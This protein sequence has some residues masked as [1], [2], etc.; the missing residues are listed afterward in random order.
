MATYLYLASASSFRS[1]ETASWDHSHYQCR[2]SA[3]RITLLPLPIARSLGKSFSF[4]S[5]AVPFH[6]SPPVLTFNAVSKTGFHCGSCAYWLRG[7]T[8]SE[9]DCRMAGLHFLSCSFL[10]GREENPKD[11]SE[12]NFLRIWRHLLC[13][14]HVFVWRED[15]HLVF[16]HSEQIL[17]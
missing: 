8:K 10:K 16:V 3:L 2:L 7:W 12:S 4:A 13:Y 6:L 1:H 11:W 14:V 15:R 17:L 5:P 9:R